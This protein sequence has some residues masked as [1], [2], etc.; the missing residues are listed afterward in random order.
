M[1]K[2]NLIFIIIT[3]TVLAIRLSVFLVPNID[4]NVS[5]FIVHHFWFGLFMIL[6]S[7][8]ISNNLTR[9]YLC[10][11]GI[12]LTIDQLFFML[13]G[14]GGDKEYWSILSIYGAIFSLIIIFLLRKIIVSNLRFLH[15][16]R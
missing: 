1:K 8:L 9:I 7:L 5:G 6:V 15:K 12:G 10:S 11:I 3:C 14:A 13:S 4:I 16:Q 2:D